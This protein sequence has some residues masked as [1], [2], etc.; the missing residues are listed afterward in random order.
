MAKGR[1]F[2]GD[3]QLNKKKVAATIIA[4]AVII[5][6]IISIKN[7]FTNK[8]LV[9]E[10][11]VRDAYFT[12]Y[13]NNK[14]G[15][16][17]NKG[18]YVVKPS[19]DEMII[20]PDSSKPVFICTYDVDYENEVYK[21]KVLNEKSEEVLSNYSN[22]RAIE[23]S[24]SNSVWYDENLL[25]Y[26]KDG[27]YGLVNYS[28]KKI[29]EP[30]YSSIHALEGTDRSI[31]IEKDG[32]KGIVNSNLENTVVDCKYNDISTLSKSSEDDG[33]ITLLDSKYGVISATGKTI[34]EN[35]Y[36]EIKHVVGGSKYV[37]ND[38][39][40]KV[41]DNEKNVILDNGFDN[42]KS[43]DGDNLVVEKGGKY[44]VITTSG[45]IKI[46]AEYEDLSH[47]YENYYVAKR[48]GKYGVISI[49]NVVC[50]NFEYNFLE[51]IKTT[52]FYQAENSNY[53]TDI[54]NRNF[55][56]KLSNV[57]I[58]EMNANENYMRVRENGEYKYYTM[59]FEN[60]K[61]TDVLKSNTLFLV[62]KDNKYGYIN[63]NGDL[64][65]DYI[66]D[67]AMEQNAYGYCAVKKDGVW[68]VLASDG[69]L[70]LKPSVNLD[71]YLYIKFVSTWHL[72]KD[73]TLNIYVK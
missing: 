14:Y 9:G 66:Y 62:K 43:I 58:S 48:D 57:V 60:V 59:H 56:T 55:E 45:E 67:D 7:L 52:D 2:D 11:T 51:Y 65:V 24:D 22:V 68:G 53:T 63:K 23:K 39:G 10:M 42:I 33:Y 28:G 17:N 38:N 37:V 50:L 27:K 13:E 40:L 54:I 71:D 4:I 47:S 1:R 20:I 46:E 21:T 5:M 3:R 70:I 49:D 19:Y 18:E 73:G 41:I 35:E 30:E 15:V 32:L 12:V 69:T 31:V 6:V 64:I 8:T 16:I 29:T 25:I 36:S 26:E 61:N 34:L 72:F 44:G